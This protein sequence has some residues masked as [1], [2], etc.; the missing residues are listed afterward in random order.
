MLYFILT[1][2][3][4]ISIGF[5]VLRNRCA[6]SA[7]RLTF[8]HDFREQF[9]TW[10]NSQ[11]KDNKT[12]AALMLQSNRIQNEMGGTGILHK[13]KP[14]FANYFLCDYPIILNIIPEIRQSFESD[15]QTFSGMYSKTID[16]YVRIID[17]SLLRH[18]GT[19]E[20]EMLQRD[21]ALRNPFMCLS[22]G[23]QQI[24]SIPLFLL[25]AFGLLRDDSIGNIQNSWLF[26]FIS[27][28]F[29]LLAATASLV[30]IFSDGDKILPV[31]QQL[32]LEV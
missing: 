5:L 3:L 19:T 12:Y 32:G 8:A 14:P 26:K 18:I 29:A 9:L 27:A 11:G 13:F 24:V 10:L 28:L 6:L 1:L 7:E 30:T 25:N 16:G 31:L 15:L 2:L 4:I 22:T 20:H 21:K 23:I 17:D